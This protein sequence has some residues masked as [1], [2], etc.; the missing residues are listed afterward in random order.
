MVERGREVVA[1]EWPECSARL[2]R[3]EMGEHVTESMS[4]HL[5]VQRLGFGVWAPGFRVEG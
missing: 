5:E 4:L 1:C 2:P 3:G